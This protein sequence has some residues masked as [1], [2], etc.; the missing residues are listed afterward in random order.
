MSS[1]SNKDNINIIC[2]EENIDKSNAAITL[3]ISPS[4]KTDKDNMT[5]FIPLSIAKNK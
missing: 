4:I 3:Y 1:K 5:I 2:G